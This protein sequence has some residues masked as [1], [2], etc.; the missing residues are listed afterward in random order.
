MF[1][2]LLT[3]EM[4]NTDEEVGN[5]AVSREAGMALGGNPGGK[6]MVNAG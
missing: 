5:R 1:D 4:L 2:P 3:S 6:F